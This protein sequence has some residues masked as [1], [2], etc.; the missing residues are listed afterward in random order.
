ME[1]NLNHG[2]FGSNVSYEQKNQLLCLIKGN[3]S[4]LLIDEENI[5]K[6]GGLSIFQ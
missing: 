5:N 1:F 4:V 3:L 6:V 2:K